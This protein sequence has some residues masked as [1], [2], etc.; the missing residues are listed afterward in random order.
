ML[1]RTLHEIY[2]SERKYLIALD[3]SVIL[4]L[5][6]QKCRH[7]SFVLI[8]ARYCNIVAQILPGFYLQFF[9]F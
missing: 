9:C 4:Y 6:G 1:A 8:R 3:I 7:H 5:S 2:L